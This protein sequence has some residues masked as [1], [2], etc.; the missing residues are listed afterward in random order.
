MQRGACAGSVKLLA[1]PP[2]VSGRL[3]FVVV[4]LAATNKPWMLDE[5]VIRPGRLGTH[6][7]V[8]P[9]DLKAREAVLSL[10]L[11][12]VPTADVS[13]AEIASGTDGYTLLS[14]TSKTCCKGNPIAAG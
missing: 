12:G 2:L 10:N 11:I 4:G 14:N 3:G 7:Y 9:P 5:A 6:I 13:L 1:S 8:G